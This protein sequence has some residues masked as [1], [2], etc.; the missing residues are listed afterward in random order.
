MLVLA[1][2]FMDGRSVMA[3]F[4]DE[5]ELYAREC[6]RLAHLCADPAMRERFFQMARD[7]RA[8]ATGDAKAPQPGSS[9]G[10]TN[11]GFASG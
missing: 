11:P 1:G 4:N 10:K 6:E 3:S 2:S 8:V 7:W 9:V 5:A